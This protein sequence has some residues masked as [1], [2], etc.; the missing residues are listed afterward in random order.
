M[1]SQYHKNDQLV[2]QL[3]D[4]KHLHDI[5]FYIWPKHSRSLRH[6][7]GPIKSDDDVLA[8]VRSVLR[9]A[10]TRPNSYE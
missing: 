9:K 4:L 6:K 3:K 1:I 7:N 10:M 5:C 8:T 2:H